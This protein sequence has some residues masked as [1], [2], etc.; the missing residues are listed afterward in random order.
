MG[1]LMDR[2]A[3]KYG[4]KV[5]YID[6][7]VDTLLAASFIWLSF[8]VREGMLDAIAKCKSNEV[9]TVNWTGTGPNGMRFVF[10]NVTCQ[11]SNVTSGGVGG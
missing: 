8:Q 5:K 6:W 10:G 11:C 7:A 4:M 9:P 2:W 3:E 1:I